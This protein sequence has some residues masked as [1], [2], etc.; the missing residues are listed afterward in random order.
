MLLVGLGASAG[1]V[2]ALEDFF[3][4]LPQANPEMA[5]VVVTHLSPEHESNL[6]SII[7]RHTNLPV[8]QVKEA[9][10][11]EPARV[12]VIPP[13]KQLSMK[14]GYI[15][16][17]DLQGMRSERAPIDLFFRTLAETHGDEAAAVVLSGTGSDGSVGLPRIKEMG[18]VTLVQDPEEA[19]YNQMPKNAIATGLVDQILPVAQMG[20]WL[21]TYRENKSKVILADNEEPDKSDSA[22]IEAEE[23][24]EKVPSRGDPLVEILAFLKV[25]T[26]HNFSLYKRSTLNRR[27]ERRLQV[28][29][30]PSL[31]IYQDFLTSHPAEVEALM[32]DL[33]ISVTNFFRD[34]EVWDFI[35]T[36]IIPGL[37]VGKDSP[38]SAV[39]V[40]VAG[41][42]T[43]EEAYTLAILLHEYASKLTL[44]PRLQIFASDLNESAINI[45]REGSYPETIALD[46]SPERLRQYFTYTDHRYRV[47]KQIRETIL[48]AN[49]DLLK[50]P[51]FSRLDLISCRNLLIYLNKEAQQQTLTVFHFAL[52][53]ERY[54]VLGT[55]ES[56]D[57][58]SQLFTSFDKKNHIYTSRVVPTFS[59][60]VPVLAPIERTDGLTQ[61][62]VEPA[63]LVSF[64]TNHKENVIL[65][66]EFINNI[67]E[68]YAPPG[69]IVDDK[70]DII[71]ISNQAGRYLQFRDGLTSVNLP[72]VI[73]PDLRLEMSSGLY[74][75]QRGNSNETR[76]IRIE[77][78]G[79]SRW[80]RLIFRPI[81]Q[82]PALAGYIL[83][84]FDEINQNLD[85]DPTITESKAG[86]DGND[87]VSR[88]K[89]SENA[90]YIR[91]LQ[92]ET[93]VLKSQLNG[94]TEQYAA[95]IE[96]LRAS[97]EE[98]KASN[99]ELQS[100]NEEMRSATEELETSR[101]EL[102]AVNEELI[103]VNQELKIKVEEVSHSNSDL[104]NLILSTD[105]A[106]I[107]LNRQ[108]VIKRYTPKVERIFNIIPSDLNRPLAHLTHHLNYSDKNFHEDIDK[109]LRDLTPITREVNTTD[110]NWYLLRILPYR[111][112]E[113][114][115]DGVVLTF[116]EITERKRSE[117]ALRESEERYRALVS[118]ATAG[119][120]RVDLEGNLQFANQKMH[121]ILGFVSEEI[122]GKSLLELFSPKMWI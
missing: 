112:L 47:R 118:Q 65:S 81:N 84:I 30:I 25:R 40:W 97:N 119:V 64:P 62:E 8:I 109:V 77:L 31:P 16:L 90:T 53:P 104:Q 34:K 113:D 69:I 58:A 48:F 43:G 121:E 56:A 27:I 88:E 44:P 46:V 54:L 83:I 9:V 98:L 78:D 93:E 6:A 66:P 35:E 51:P 24:L 12:Y 96:E 41:C 80:V 32:R 23:D 92:Q 71:H 114:R 3:E 49:H 122:M 13:G 101:E 115:I 117:E 7:Q 89:E 2:A 103:T 68:V 57:N 52:R 11:V 5:F 67:M 120:A 17:V 108:L 42:A 116:L 95:S 74:N 59:R 94:T 39:R 20:N 99:E 86:T 82:P 37:F 91:Q 87:Q 50:D 4:Y 38:E 105:I 107:F 61:K 45:A 102:Q 85:F 110:D 19:E 15:Q 73:H 60:P 76:R 111:T 10:P 63:E 21:V 55:S 26:G 79:V 14:D 36:R 75:A 100:I 1:G 70:F 22:S 33:L 28:N 72:K 18:G 29:N 106:T